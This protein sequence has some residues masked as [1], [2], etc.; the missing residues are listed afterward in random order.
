MTELHEEVARI[1]KVAEKLLHETER[2]RRDVAI[3]HGR[4]V[5]FDKEVP[6]PAPTPSHLQIRNLKDA[7]DVVEGARRGIVG[8]DRE[9]I[10]IRAV[11]DG[12]AADAY[13]R[14]ELKPYIKEPPPR[15]RDPR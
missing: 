8:C 9:L 3:L 14:D 5:P 15:R 1:A 12:I 11:M 6:L 13:L 7:L 4:L 10:A 2:L